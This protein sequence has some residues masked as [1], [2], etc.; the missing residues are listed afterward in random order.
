MIDASRTGRTVIPGHET[1]NQPTSSSA[2]LEK[3]LE[4]V[5]DDPNPGA[6]PAFLLMTS[7]AEPGRLYALDHTELVIGRSKYADIRVSERA[8]SQQH[9]KIVRNHDRHRLVDLGST[10]G[11]FV[12]EQRVA[13]TTLQFGDII[14]T[15]HTVFT[16]MS[17]TGGSEL[18]EST[19]AMP[20]GGR[21]RMAGL[22]GTALVL[23]PRPAHGLSI[24]QILEV[25]P[26]RSPDDDGMD[27][28][29]YVLIGLEFL[30]RYWLSIA[31]LTL[32]GAGMGPVSY[33]YFK[34]SQ[35]AMFEV[36]LMPDAAGAPVQNRR[37]APEVFFRSAQQNFLRP[38]L[39]RESLVDIGEEEVTPTRVLGVQSKLSLKKYPKEPTIYVGQY[40]AATADEAI[41]FLQAHLARYVESE[42]DKTLHV[43][44]LEVETVEGQLRE[45]DAEL[46]K[47]QKAILAFKE[48]YGDQLP[49]QAT[50][51]YDERATVNT[52]L[53]DAE[54][55]LERARTALA[56]ARDQLQS[57]SPWMESLIAE[58]Q[59]YE[60]EIK[61]VK[62]ELAAKRASGMADQHP[63]VLA[64]NEELNQ[65]QRLSGDVL[66][67][68]PTAGTRQRNP[69]YEERR[70]ALADAEAAVTVARS[71][72]A[73]LTR[74][75]RVSDDSLTA[76]P[77]IERKWEELT[78]SLAA[79][80]SI[81]EQLFE[82]A[83][84]SR[85]QL[86]LERAS[87]SGRYDVITPP[88]VEQSSPLIIVLMRT[89]IAAFAGFMFGIALG[90]F[91]DLRRII[92]ARLSAMR[93]R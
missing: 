85:Y 82:K 69:A 61:N 54:G 36:E 91:R 45:A 14:R 76:L 75:L 58:A 84:N 55:E 34:P 62:K 4:V 70:R 28:L 63:E 9:A 37:G 32:L 27:I 38:A 80:K 59:P 60:D 18:S 16:Y 43:M 13:E 44:T 40:E 26:P 35:N 50:R 52:E 8:I 3:L 71:E 19:L 1:G 51:F 6:P 48:Q 56:V 42:I 67:K 87:A 83:N 11:T 21:G 22:A 24:P 65:L 81:R 30:R 90:A 53:G 10:N 68:A 31:I 20:V 64:L 57:E 72:V 47:T 74:E 77:E 79:R 93:S 7:G 39:I 5:A 46:D 33:H 78:R 29:G 17:A 25:P 88:H 12:N 2:G 23:P 86:G 92:S 89:A 49:D 15:G 66:R 73:R 41:R